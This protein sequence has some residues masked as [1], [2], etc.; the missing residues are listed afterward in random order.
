MNE[1][2]KTNPQAA[3]SQYEVRREEG[4]ATLSAIG[5]VSMAATA[6][7]SRG[8][9]APS[10]TRWLAVL[11]F[12]ILVYL[13]GSMA[14]I[15]AHKSPPWTQVFVA[16]LVVVLIAT[17]AFWRRQV[18]KFRARQARH[19][20]KERQERLNSLAH[21]TANCLNAIRANL[22][23]ASDANPQ[24]SAAEHRKQVEQALER[25][26]AAL[27]ETIGVG[28]ARKTAASKVDPAAGKSKA[29]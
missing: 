21:E 9:A 25:I 15:Y 6:A 4:Q 7:V 29:A 10:R 11:G 26:E 2:S 27:T 18:W 13:A 28:P 8:A 22:P 23:G 16:P 17:L 14:A 5:D 1:Q 24:P 20:E 19:N 3:S 12:F